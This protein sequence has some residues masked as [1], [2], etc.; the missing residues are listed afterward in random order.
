[1]PLEATPPELDPAARSARWEAAGLGPQQGLETREGREL[2]VSMLAG[3]RQLAAD[4]RTLLALHG[5]RVGLWHTDALT[6]LTSWGG[7]PVVARLAVAPDG[8][9]VAVDS[10]AGVEIRDAASGTVLIPALE[11]GGL[12][13]WEPFASPSAAPELEGVTAGALAP[14]GSWLVAAAGDAPLITRWELD[15]HRRGRVLDTRLDRM[16]RADPYSSDALLARAELAA[17]A[18][19]WSRC[20]DLLGQAEQV[21]AVVHPAD[22]L[23]ALGLAGRLG[24]ARELLARLSPTMIADPAVQAWAV[25]L[26]AQPEG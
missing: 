1:V 21:G 20:A 6:V 5:E 23:R 10:G 3:P 2:E 24:G 15:P 26:E 7:P 18:G 8:R 25:W 14:D 22:Q 11:A 12:P 16:L 17:L 9:L 4:E 13:G 19:R